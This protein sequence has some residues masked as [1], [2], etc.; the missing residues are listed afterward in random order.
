MIGEVLKR[1]KEKE[2]DYD[3]Y[4][5]AQKFFG[6]SGQNE[7]EQWFI[8]SF[9][10]DLGFDNSDLKHSIRRTSKDVKDTIK[11]WKL[12]A[13]SWKDDS[14]RVKAESLQTAYDELMPKLENMTESE[15]QNLNKIQHN[16]NARKNNWK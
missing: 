5:A 11:N 12:Q 3:G 1:R 10:K 4:Y 2:T 6:V 7:S 16:I 13:E 15:Y 14:M 8:A 9:L